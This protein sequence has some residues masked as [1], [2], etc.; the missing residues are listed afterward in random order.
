MSNDDNGS[1]H[2]MTWIGAAVAIALLLVGVW[3]ARELTA[4]GR[5]QDCLMQGRTNCA[6]IQP[7]Q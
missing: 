5:L 3:L 1:G 2:R 7:S 6:A 4:A